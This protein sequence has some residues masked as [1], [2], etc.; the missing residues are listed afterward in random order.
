MPRAKLVELFS[1]VIEVIGR[2]DKIYKNG[3]D[4]L[5]PQRIEAV[6][7]NSVTA[8]LAAEKMC[9]FLVGLGFD[10][11]TNE[12]IVNRKKNLTF[13]QVLKRIARDISYHKGAFIHVN[14]DIEGKVNHLDVL[15]F[16]NCRVSEEDDHDY[17]GFVWHSKDWENEN[18]GLFVNKRRKEKNWF[19]PY[20]P[21]I[22]VINAQRK[23]DAP[24][25]ATPE[26]L[27]KQYR[28]QVMFFSLEDDSIYPNSWIDPAYN[29]ADTEHRISLFRNDRIRNGFLGA[30][31]IMIPEG[32]DEGQ[33]IVTDEQ[34]RM[35]LGSDNA[36]N[37]LKIEVKA[38][39]DKKLADYI[40]VETLKS[41]VDTEQFQYDEKKIEEK[42][43]NCYKVP[44]LLIKKNDSALFGPS[45][46]VLAMVQEI[47]QMETDMTRKAIENVFKKLFPDREF[48]IKKLIEETIS[49]ESEDDGTAID[50]E[51][52]L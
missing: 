43:L 20:N 17:S 18:L 6:I 13:Y 49:T 4:N 40:H 2:K 44:E 31:I 34:I 23:A 25:N 14:Y 11:T 19:Y 51:E 27:I 24:N 26:Q 42:I 8:K 30:N 33:E 16:K 46:K 10:E 36:S 1:R 7:N 12:E 28:G 22:K 9:A 35:L 48:E 52:Q 38:E 32:E 15:K 41:E 50:N 21:D 29:D 47:F 39:G 37:V 45:G 3:A 5:Y